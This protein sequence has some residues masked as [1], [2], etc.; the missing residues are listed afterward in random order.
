M[1]KGT[2]GINR[3]ILQ[4]GTIFND[5]ILENLIRIIKKI[6][7]CRNYIIKNAFPT[8]FR[9]IFEI[10]LKQT[11]SPFSRHQNTSQKNDI[12]NVSGFRRVQS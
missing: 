9:F 3:A 7:N 2:L 12:K 10:S 1:T 4:R 6:K 8:I 11:I 5:S